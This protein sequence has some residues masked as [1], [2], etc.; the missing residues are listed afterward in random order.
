MLREGPRISSKVTEHQTLSVELGDIEVKEHFRYIRNLTE[1]KVREIS[2]DLVGS[3][4]KLH[5]S[6]VDTLYDTFI[7]N[8][9]NSVNK[10]CALR[11]VNISQKPWVK[12]LNLPK[13]MEIERTTIFKVTKAG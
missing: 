5:S 10:I 3:N 13:K 6:S 1:D 11:K 4:R 2:Q 7:D 12:E 8:I 9:S